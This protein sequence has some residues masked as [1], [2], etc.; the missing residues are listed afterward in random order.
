MLGKTKRCLAAI[1]LALALAVQDANA[2]DVDIIAADFHADGQGR[3]TVNVTLRHQD[4]DWEHYAD[5]WQVV[6]EKGKVL[7]DRVLFHPHIN[8][9]PFTRSLSGVQIP[10]DTSVVYITA[11]DKKHG[12]TDNRLRVDLAKTK[13]GRLKVTSEQ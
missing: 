6:D 10:E 13:M 4:T 5:N 9:Q 7:G 12:W 3:W 1:L 8:E 2:G 11:H